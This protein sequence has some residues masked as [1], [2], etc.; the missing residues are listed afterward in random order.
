MTRGEIFTARIESI[1]SG[2]AGIAR[3]DGK[4]VFVE[5]TAP[6]DN[7]KIKI[8]KEKKNWAEGVLL[9]ILEASPSRQEAKCRFYG[10]CGGCSLQHLNYKAQIKAKTAIL[11]GAFMHIGGAEAPEIKTRLSSPYGYRNRLQ[12]HCETKRK[13]G[14][15]QIGFKERKSSSIVIVDNCPIADPGIQKA[16]SENR[17]LP[18][19][20]KE[21]FSVYSRGSTFLAEGSRE[22]GKVSILD[23]ELTLDVKHFFQSNAAMLELLITDLKAVAEKAEKNLPMADIYCGVGTFASFLAQ[24]F[25]EVDL[26]EE[27]KEALAL[28]K[29]NI[30]DGVKAN[31]YALKDSAWA[32]MLEKNGKKS[33]GFMVLDPPRDGL[34][35]NLRKLLAKQGPNLL[36]YVSC[37][38]A[39]QARDSRVLMDG[40]YNLEEL[41]M[42]DFY[43]QTEHIESLA[44]FRK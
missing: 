6:G 10:I 29:E 28:A 42:Y 4:S 20:R 32:G 31:F 43:P 8:T 44:V 22:R 41:F 5:L 9:D 11:R 21:R 17:L 16:I 33:W 19:S 35:D 24:N 25:P 37:D 30:P 38:S 27:N 15:K 12:F 18:P 13:T 3:Y 14:E 36:A 26:V 7:A 40:G 39:T 34:S 1:A 23:R 2:G